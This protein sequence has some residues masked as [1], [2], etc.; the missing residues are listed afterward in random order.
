M[1]TEDQH[2]MIVMGT[3][4]TGAQEWYCP[5]CGRHLILQWPPNYKR[6]ILDEGNAQ[7]VHAGGTCESILGLENIHPA[8][9]EDAIEDKPGATDFQEDPYLLPWLRWIGDRDF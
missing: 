2:Q 3:Y 6:I 7:A 4:P 9:P 8:R 5:T 1:N